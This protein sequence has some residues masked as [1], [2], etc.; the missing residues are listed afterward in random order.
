[1]L[2]WLSFVGE[3]LFC[4]TAPTTKSPDGSLPVRES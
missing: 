2:L 3:A 4:V 1:M